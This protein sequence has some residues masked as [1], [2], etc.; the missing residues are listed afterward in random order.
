MQ[1]AFT[2]SG[3]DVGRSYFIADLCCLRLSF[4][5]KLISTLAI[6]ILMCEHAY[7]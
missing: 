1:Q 4:Q 3:F 2:S 7:V 5:S 6:S